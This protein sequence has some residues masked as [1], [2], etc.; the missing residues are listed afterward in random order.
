MVEPLRE[1]MAGQCSEE[2]D[3][4]KEEVECALTSER[5]QYLK[6]SNRGHP[7]LR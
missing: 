1:D 4:M 6:R 2:R 3:E 7:V 5:F